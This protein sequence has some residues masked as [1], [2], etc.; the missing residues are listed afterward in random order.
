VRTGAACILDGK[1]EIYLVIKINTHDF[2]EVK[3]LVMD[4]KALGGLTAYVEDCHFQAGKFNAHTLLN[5]AK[6]IGL[7]QGVLESH[8]VKTHLVGATTWQNQIRVISGKI[9]RGKEAS[10]AVAKLLGYETKNHNEADAVCIAMYGYR[11]R[12]INA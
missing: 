7:C 10:L 2:Q 11:Q 12:K 6:S 3:D 8:G 1:G 5:H 9:Q 4:Y